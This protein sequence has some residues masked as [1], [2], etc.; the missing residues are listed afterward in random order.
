MAVVVE[1]KWL[2]NLLDKVKAINRVATFNFASDGLVVNILDDAGII[3]MYSKYGVALFPDYKEIGEFHIDVEDLAKMIKGSFKTDGTVEISMRKDMVFIKGTTEK[4]RFRVYET[5]PN[6]L[7]TEDPI[8]EKYGFIKEGMNYDVVATL[9]VNS[10]TSLPTADEYRISYNTKKIEIEVES[11][12]GGYTRELPF[13][14]PEFKD[15]DVS[16]S[17]VVPGKY[18]RKVVKNIK[19]YIYV[20]LHPEQPLLLSKVEADYKETYYISLIEVE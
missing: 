6:K 17:I 11:V 4:I 19:D 14:N 9:D 15:K 10:L 20:G 1:T 3:G 13:V 5:P 7:F 8:E 18:F 12:Y 2:K 16:G